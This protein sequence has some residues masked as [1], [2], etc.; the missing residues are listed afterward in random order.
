MRLTALTTGLALF[1]AQAPADNII[2]SNTIIQDNLCVGAAC[3][4]PENYLG[5]EATVRLKDVY[6]RLEFIDT[7]TPSGDFPSNNWRLRAND[8]FQ[9]GNELFAV[10]NLSENTRPFALLGAAPTNSLVVAEDGQIGFGTFMPQRELHIV[11]TTSPTL[12]MEQSAAGGL[13]AQTWDMLFNHGNIYIRDVNLGTTPFSIFKNAPTNSMRITQDGNLGN[14]TGTPV[15][16]LHI[17]RDN[18]TAKIRVE[19]ETGISTAREML[20]MRNNGG[21]YFTLANTNSGTTWYFTHENNAPNRFIIADAVADGPEMSLSADGILTVPGGFVVNNTTLN[22]PD[23]VFEPDY[24]LRPLSEVQ[25]FID[26]HS[27]LPDV[28]SA[29]DIAK[30]GLDM[31]DMQM[32]LLQKVE[33]LTLYTL[34]QEA[35]IAAQDATNAA[36]LARLERLEARER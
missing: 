35:R 33:E 1:A 34:E 13:P 31:T 18:G 6:T 10:E 36:L 23:Y 19:E 3:N 4:D 14:G 9:F 30:D 25:A 2:N 22:V 11:S 27:H 20:E 32:R 16:S 12:R 8:N 5:G 28:P 21:S 7:S 24:A 26:T 15:A 29:A 17:R